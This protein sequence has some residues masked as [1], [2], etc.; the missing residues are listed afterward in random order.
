M[1]DTNGIEGAEEFTEVKGLIT[2]AVLLCGRDA[3][4]GDA[5]ALF[6]ASVIGLNIGPS[7]LSNCS[8]C[9]TLCDRNDLIN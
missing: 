9:A 3:V 4:E 2:R 7:L 1:A 8:R 6:M 5:V